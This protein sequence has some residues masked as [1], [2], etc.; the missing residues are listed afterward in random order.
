MI[1]TKEFNKFF[2]SFDTGNISPEELEKIK[3]DMYSGWEARQSEIDELKA[4]ISEL[5]SKLQES[6]KHQV[7]HKP[8]DWS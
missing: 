3:I 7:K 6:E 5:E 8:L 1:Y 4:R 2:E